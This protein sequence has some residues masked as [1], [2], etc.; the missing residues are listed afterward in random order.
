MDARAWG[1]AAALLV[2]GPA[3]AHPMGTLSTNRS[4][5]V[6]TGADGT[7][8][9]YTVDF[10]EVP[11]VAELER[12]RAGGES[13][14][15]EARMSELLP[16]L[17]LTVDGEARP[18]RPEPCLAS[19]TR[20]EGELTV[21]ALMCRLDADPVAA[22]VV[23]F[24]D[25]NF[26]GSPGWREIRFTAGEDVPLPF[27]SPPEEMTVASRSARVGHVD[28]GGAVA[29]R[30]PD[31]FAAL[32]TDGGG[33]GFYLLAL[34]AAAG[35]G[36]GHAL[37]PGHGKT[38]VAAYL[39]GSRGTVAQ[40]LLLGLAVTATHVSSVLLLGIGTLY[41]SKY[42]VAEA[43]YPWIGVASGLGVVAVGAGLLR[44]RWARW[45]G[46]PAHAGGWL[47]HDHGP[48]GHDHVVRDDRGEPVTPGRLL[49]LG[50]TG[51][52]V[53]CPS[54]L[55]V[56][57]SA[58]ALH[59][60]VFGL[61]LVVSF[62]IGLAAVLV[63][64]GILVVRAQAFLARLSGADRAAAWVPVASAVVVTALGLGI[65]ARSAIEGGLVRL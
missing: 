23:A 29:A 54:A 63:G 10:A 36:A 17:A 57:L 4:A 53:P 50:V 37:S 22:G 55:V 16:A 43:L 2:A 6:H 33:G 42:V 28:P 35:L 45:R 21:V 3:A 11:S 12:V 48:G 7:W 20:G 38:L 64:I 32:V 26:A 44:A 8:V 31:A 60:I 39:V 47:D 19:T 62:S 25:G 15:A 18:L 24:T 30:T 65:V 41:L 52:A 61:A 9:D 27:A 51:G 59:R 1:V 56:L 49:A 5:L 34:L 46:A 40:A 13:A 14:W 58:I